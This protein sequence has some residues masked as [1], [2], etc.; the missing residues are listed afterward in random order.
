MSQWKDILEQLR[1]FL[2]TAPATLIALIAHEMAHAWVSYALGDPT[3]RSDGRLTPNPLKHL[4]PIGTI[5]LLLFHF[6]WARPVMVN[7]QYYKKPRLGMALT[8]L[9]GPA[10]NLILAFLFTGLYILLAKT[11]GG[12]SAGVAGYCM[13]LAYYSIF[14][15]IGLGTFNL[16]PIPPLDGSKILGAV[17]PDRLYF[18]LMRYERYGT[19]ML[20]ILLYS[21]LLDKP[22]DAVR[23]FLI[24]LMLQAWL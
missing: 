16:I 4:D 6:G 13:L 11:T 21:N 24:R 5:C 1:L 10:T 22:L 7:P 9:A 8:A 14:L 15:N 19:V 2:Y 18:S 23:E 17:L 3:P 20:V 12:N